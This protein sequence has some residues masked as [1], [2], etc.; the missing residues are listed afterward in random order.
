MYRAA[1]EKLRTVKTWRTHQQLNHNNRI[2]GCDNEVNR[3]RKGQKIHG[4]GRGRRC[5]VCSLEKYYDRPRISDLK[6]MDRERD[7]VC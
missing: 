5:R 6:Q 7:Y 1:I 3:F 2:C 4:C